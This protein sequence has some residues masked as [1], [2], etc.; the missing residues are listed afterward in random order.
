MLRLS[1]VVTGVVLA[2]WCTFATAAPCA[3]FTDVD[4]SS[5]FC[6][7]VE[8]MKNRGI[9]LG[10][11]PTLYD[12]FSP[13]TRLQM[14]VFM[15]RLGYQN[16]FLQGG[17]SFGATTIVGTD[18][19]HPLEIHVN[20]A[21]A[22]RFEPHGSGPNVIGGH[23][24]NTVL[25]G[26]NSTIGG[27][28][29]AGST[30]HE[31]SD[32]TFTRSCTNQAAAAGTVAGGFANQAGSS[33]FVGGGS[34][35]SASVG[36][37]THSVVGGGSGNIAAGLGGTVPGGYY[38]AAT[39]DFSFAAGFRAK[40]TTDGTFMWADSRPFDFSP[41]VGNFFGARA[42]GGVGFTVAI[43]PTTGAVTQFCNYLPGYSGWSCTSD[44]NAKEN[45]APADGEAVLAELVA[46][47]LSSWNYKGADPALRMLG[48]TAQDFFGAFGLGADDKTIA[49]GNL[50]G[51]A[52]AAIQ[53]LNAKLEATVAEQARENA[54]LRA[55]LAEIRAL[56]AGRR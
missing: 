13:V 23:P 26:S 5:P 8:W 2:T 10:L 28:G 42:T 36:D 54:R 25:Y 14:A 50:D 44:R 33:S 19:N 43:D 1:A 20:G 24:G 41:S 12:P 52:L 11:T 9:T 32:G 48:P 3:G 4:D 46:M 17:N 31:P 16:A 45:F 40:A 51:V 34:S 21:R 39:G 37:G 35:N 7:N 27:G 55:E 6:V 56:L 47:P 49:S 38:N 53:G 18:D 22:M 15:Y 30:C 29:A